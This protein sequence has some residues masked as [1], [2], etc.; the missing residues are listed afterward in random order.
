[1]YGQYFN[2]AAQI[3]NYL[4]ANIASLDPIEGQYDVKYSWNTPYFR[5][6]DTWIYYIV[7]EPVTNILTFYVYDM[8][9]TIP[10][11][12]KARIVN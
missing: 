11:F 10:D 1:M 12:I 7:K 9:M 4:A 2:S 3:L 8:F 6:E 5:G